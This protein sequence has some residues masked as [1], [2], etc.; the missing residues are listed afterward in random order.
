MRHGLLLLLFA[1]LMLPAWSAPTL[2]DAA[3]ALKSGND[4]KALAICGKLPVSFGTLYNQGLAWRNLGDLPKARVSFEKA[5]LLRPQDLATRRRLREIDGRLGEKVLALDV[6]STP[7]WSQS[8]VE[9]LLLLPGLAMLGLGLNARRGGGL[10][11]APTALIWLTA[12]GLTALVWWT[13][14]PAQRAVVVDSGA[15]LLPGPSPDS[16]GETLPGGVL[17]QLLEQ[18]NHYAKVKLGDGK[19][20]W[21]RQA[22]LEK[23]AV[24]GGL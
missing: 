4:R 3:E 9:I 12:L 11:L 10:P 24:P 6:R 8:Q 2:D 7:W 20:G 21:L 23:L 19:T 16:P 1:C 18:R 14:P 5:L 17:V 22:Q 15:Q 13:A